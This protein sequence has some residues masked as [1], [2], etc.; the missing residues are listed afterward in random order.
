MENILDKLK[1]IQA[2]AEAG[3][4]GERENAKRKLEALLAK[5]GL[6]FEDL[7]TKQL[8]QVHYYRYK[9]MTE[10]QLLAQCHVRVVPRSRPRVSYTRKGR[11]A[12]GYELTP[13]EQLEL[14]PLWSYYRR[15]WKKELGAF[16]MAFIHKHDLF[17]RGPKPKEEGDSTLTEEEAAKIMDMMS[18]LSKSDYISTNRLLPGASTCQKKRKT[19]RSK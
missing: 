14:G 17:P 13:L 6:T 3:V 18:G 10:R 16:F 12:I 5:H 19:Q 7:A 15:L 8:P 9:G 1:K 11:R 4:G 2:L